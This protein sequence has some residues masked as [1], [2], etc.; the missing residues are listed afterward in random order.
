MFWGRTVENQFT[1]ITLL[2]SLFPSGVEHHEQLDSQL[3]NA[4]RAN[5]ND[6]P[7]VR[8]A[9]ALRATRVVDN[10]FERV[11]TRGQQFEAVDLLAI[12]RAAPARFCPCK[13]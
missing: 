3:G 13:L 5:A 12:L 8:T 7:N 1:E 6:L 4:Q 11:H 10:R 2:V 9:T